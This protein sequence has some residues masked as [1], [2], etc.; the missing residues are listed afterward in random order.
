ME[1]FNANDL[2]NKNIYPT[3]K[4]TFQ[5]LQAGHKDN[6]PVVVISTKQ[7]T[8]FDAEN[9]KLIYQ[10]KYDNFVQITD[11]LNLIY[12]DDTNRKS[13]SLYDISHLINQ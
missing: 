4:K 10:L 11:D 1:L 6:L 3:G 13:I 2:S 12:H 7:V 5:I 9:G 8:Y